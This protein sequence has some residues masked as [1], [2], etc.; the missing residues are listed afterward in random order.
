MIP[1]DLCGHDKPDFILQS[2]GLD[3]PLVRCPSCGLYYVGARSSRLAFEENASAAETVARVRQANRNFRDLDR[4]EERRLALL[5]SRWRVDLIRRYCPAGRLLEVGCARGDFLEIAREVFDVEGV[6]PNP[7]L[8]GSARHV[9]PVHCGLLE[10]STSRGFDIAAS[11]HVIE[12]VESPRRFVHQLSE[13]VRPGGWVVIETPNIN[14]PAFRLL[15]S[16]WRQF[17]PEHYYFFDPRTVTRLLQSA[18]LTVEAVSHVG[19]Y[20]SVDLILNR[21]S[22]YSRALGGLIAAARRAGVSRLT[23]RIDP[24]DIMIVFARRQLNGADE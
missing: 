9:A 1:C 16:R 11:F 4:S 19:K 18:G 2:R 17:I 22:R 12:H 3:G 5:N 10:S 7:E 15:R 24:R 13:R 6:E 14:S 23:V 21:L 20:A 8:A